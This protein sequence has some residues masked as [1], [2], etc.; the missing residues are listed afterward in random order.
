MFAS[1]PSILGA[2]VGPR[3]LA[4]ALGEAVMVAVN[5]ALACPYCTGLHGNLA[6]MAG[7]D[8]VALQSAESVDEVQRVVDD[9]A[10]AYARIFAEAQVTGEGAAVEDAFAAVVALHGDGKA[11]SV[12]ALCW[13]LTWGA[14]GGNTLNAALKGHPDGR[15]RSPFDLAFAGYYAPLFGVIAAMNAGLRLAPGDGKVPTAFFPAL[16]VTLTV[17]GGLWLTP[18]ALMAHVHG[19]TRGRAVKK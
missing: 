5:S 10:T 12:R 6:R 3:A 4:P 13:F 9:P 18:V 2:Y 19:L 8:A 16:G 15:R 17:A 7:V 11:R 14:R 1:L